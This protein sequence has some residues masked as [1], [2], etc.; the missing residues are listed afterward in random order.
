MTRLIKFPLIRLIILLAITAVASL[1][2]G[3]RLAASIPVYSDPA[4]AENTSL[5][6][7]STQPDD[8]R[9]AEQLIA[10][11]QRN[12]DVLRNENQRL[13][14]QIHDQSLAQTT[15]HSA[16]ATT[17]AGVVQ[18]KDQ[19]DSLEREKQERKANDVNNWIINKQKTDKQFDINTELSRRFEQESIDPLWAEQQENHYRQL[20]G[21]QDKLRNFALRDTQCRSTQCEV[22]FSISSPEQSVQLLQT[23]SSDLKGSEILVATDAN[24]GI[25][26]LYISS[27]QK[28][29]ELH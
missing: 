11:L 12:I 22:T 15:Q 20:F 6:Q 18:L 7:A 4:H 10:D 9:N 23:I 26:K 27:D 25:S 1:W 28:G 3:M 13:S 14:L 19:I 8:N 2:L 5:Q 17:P 24:Q 16:S 21:A 29:F